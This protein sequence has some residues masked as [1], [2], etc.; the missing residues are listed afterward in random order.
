LVTVNLIAKKG[1]K[2]EI[3]SRVQ[4]IVQRRKCISLLLISLL[5]LSVLIVGGCAQVPTQSVELSATVGRDI[6]EVYRAHREL[7]VIL[8]DRMKNDVNRFIDDVYAPYQIQKLLEED[9]KDF[10]K[11][12]PD[13]LFFVLDTAIKNPN[14]NDAQKNVLAAMDVFVKVV[15]GE[16]ESYREMRLKPVIEQEQKVLA[17][18][19]RSYNQIHYANSIVTGHLASVVKVHDAQEEILREFGL[20]GLRGN[21]GEELAKTSNRVAG[22]VTNAKKLEGTT[23]EIGI[24]INKLTNELD[25]IFNG[26]ETEEDLE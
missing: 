10:K 20:E 15:R 4:P 17:A 9:R 6:V 5:L 3:N 25:N 23:E 8:F 18:I 7:A 21:I 1:D 11:N 22:F 19:D 16:I 13:S 24:E 14:D 2:M 12:D 26:K